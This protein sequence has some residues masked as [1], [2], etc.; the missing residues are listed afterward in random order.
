[1]GIPKKLAQ[2]K[3]M[4]VYW[5]NYVNYL[6]TV[7]D[8]QPNVGNG[9]HKPPQ[10]V[11]Y[12]KPFSDKLADAQFL[13]A[14]A[15]TSLW[16]AYKTKFGT[17]SKD[18]IASTDTVLKNTGYKAAKVIITT[19]LSATAIT[20]TAKTTKRKYAS[21]GGESGGIAFGRKTPAQAEMTAYNEIVDAIKA[22]S[23]NPKTTR[24]SRSK[25]KY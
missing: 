5:D 14:T 18:D 21:Y 22:E 13:K 4:A 3:R 17:N 25:E 15:T 7:D 10:T 2:G 24:I 19:G 6:N 1:M 12:L 16:T 8:R 11:L 23:F 9:K 20:K